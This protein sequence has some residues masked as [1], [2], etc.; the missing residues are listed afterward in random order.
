MLKCLLVFFSGAVTMTGFV[1]AT[2]ARTSA[3]VMLGFVIATIFY[4]LLA[5]ILGPSR[6]VRSLL[7]ITGKREHQ[8]PRRT[9]C[10]RAVAERSDVE[11][12]VISALVQLGAGRSAAVKATADAVLQSPQE[13]E[14][15]FRTAVGL[16]HSQRRV[17]EIL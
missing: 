5:F 11:Q 12:D 6:I 1:V 7:W 10:K 4:G 9:L 2:G 16:L 3:L 17:A 8:R 15:L 14:P 13:F